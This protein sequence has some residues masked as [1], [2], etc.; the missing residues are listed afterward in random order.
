VPRADDLCSTSRRSRRSGDTHAFIAMR[1][2]GGGNC[3]GKTQFCARRSQVGA[4][5]FHHAHDATDDCVHWFARI[6]DSDLG[7]LL[8]LAL[9]STMGSRLLLL[10]CQLCD[11]RLRRCRSSMDVADLGSGGKHH[12]RAD[13]RVVGELP[14][15]N[16][17]QA[18]RP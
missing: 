11:R 5:P 9:F 3:L 15:R 6:G 13:V 1:W 2:V 10:G 16:R 18:S 17:E 12:R 7:V 8:S 4:D 14:V